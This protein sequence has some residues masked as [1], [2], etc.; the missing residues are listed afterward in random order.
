MEKTTI[1]IVAIAVVLILAWVVAMVFTVRR[2]I[3]KSKEA[4]EK[5]SQD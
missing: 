5:A 4:K 1:I 2:A 3:R